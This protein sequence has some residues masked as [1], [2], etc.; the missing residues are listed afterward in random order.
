LGSAALGICAETLRA[1]NKNKHK[2]KVLIVCDKIMKINSFNLLD[3]L[4]EVSELSPIKLFTYKI[5]G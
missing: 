5:P 3:K 4:F 1:L 2:E